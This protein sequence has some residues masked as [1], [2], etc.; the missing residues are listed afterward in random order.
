MIDEHQ[1]FESEIRDRQSEVDDVLKGRK[2]SD[3]DENAE[4]GIRKSVPPRKSIKHPRCQ[5]LTDRWKQLW[6]ES[7]DYGSKLQ[8]LRNYLSE[9]KRLESFSFDEWKQRYLDWTDNGKSR[10]SDL[11][12]RIDKSGTGKVPR[13]AFIDGI[14]ASSNNIYSG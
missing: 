4:T 6:T 8:D 13:K 5:Q 7:L 14:I 10:I 1:Q 3:S 11:F 2:R 12:R 9:M